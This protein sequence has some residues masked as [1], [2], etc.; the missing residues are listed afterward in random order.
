MM[1]RPNIVIIGASMPLPASG[2]ISS[3]CSGSAS[4][5]M[6]APTTSRPASGSRPVVAIRYE[7][8]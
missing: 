7:L 2:A 1:D 3:R 5:A 8:R 4:S 6:T